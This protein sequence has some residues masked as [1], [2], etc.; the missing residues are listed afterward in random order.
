MWGYCSPYYQ[1]YYLDY[2]KCS[3]DTDTSKIPESSSCNADNLIY[4]WKGYYYER[5]NATNYGKFTYLNS[6][7]AYN[8]ECPYGKKMC[9]ILDELGNK[10]CLPLSEE[11]PINLL[12]LNLSEI[13]N[14]N[15]MISTLNGKIIYY[16]N[17]ATENGTVVEGLF[18]DSDLLIKYKNEECKIIDEGY[19]GTLLKD[20]FNKLYKGSLDFDPYEDNNIDAYGKSYLKW[21]IPGHGKE[22]NISLIQIYKGQYSF[23]VSSNKEIIKPIKNFIQPLIL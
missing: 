22:K 10:L 1:D 4:F 21:C 15:Y 9:G 12:T 14:Y 5:Q 11:S 19:I 7:I 3:R 8:E 20:H 18:V 17:E 13:Q 6:A 16:T 23:N 2:S